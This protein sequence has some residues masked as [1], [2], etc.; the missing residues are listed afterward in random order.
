MVS[1]FGLSLLLGAS[2]SQSFSVFVVFPV[3]AILAAIVFALGTMQG[4]GYSLIAFVICL[5]SIALQAGYMGGVVIQMLL[6][7]GRRSSQTT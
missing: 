4:A 7:A 5:A 6:P 2:F 1:I 3:T